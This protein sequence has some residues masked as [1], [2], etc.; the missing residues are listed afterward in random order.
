MRVPSKT[1]YFPPIKCA[2]KVRTP[3]REF[4]SLTSAPRGG[5]FSSLCWTS[6]AALEHLK[7]PL[8][9]A[10]THITSVM[11]PLQKM[12]SQADVDSCE[13]AWSTQPGCK[14]STVGRY[15]AAFLQWSRAAQAARHTRQ[16]RDGCCCWTSNIC[17]VNLK[18]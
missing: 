5:M 10:R 17:R 13:G 11:T 16:A 2:R 3:R 18:S 14:P 8:F 12:N 7:I 4:G 1:Q 6:F 9:E 15:Y